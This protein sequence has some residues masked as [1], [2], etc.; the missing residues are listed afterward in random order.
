MEPYIKASI[1][2]EYINIMIE[3]VN[4][5]INRVPYEFGFE[6]NF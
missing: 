1:I 3:I 5:L 2:G 4:K 6:N